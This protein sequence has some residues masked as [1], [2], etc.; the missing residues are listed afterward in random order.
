MKRLDLAGGT[1]LIDCSGREI[2]SSTESACAASLKI[3]K[4][5]DLE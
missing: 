1:Q 3:M 5:L 2:S 4:R